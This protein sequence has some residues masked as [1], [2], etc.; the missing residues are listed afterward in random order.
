MPKWAARIWLEITGVRAGHLQ[1]INSGDISKEGIEL[2]IDRYNTQRNSFARLWNLLNAKRGYGW[3]T[4][5]W[6]WVID[7]KRV[8]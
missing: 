2:D 7:Y 6:V 8:K 5:P 3:D 1:E 4:N